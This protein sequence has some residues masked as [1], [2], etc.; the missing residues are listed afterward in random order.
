[1]QHLREK[2]KPKVIAEVWE[3]H[4]MAFHLTQGLIYTMSMSR[5]A[6]RIPCPKLLLREEYGCGWVQS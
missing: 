4:L 5:G 3:M 2:K 1:M 6:E